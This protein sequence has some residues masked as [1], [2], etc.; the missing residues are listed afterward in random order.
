MTFLSFV[1]HR[2]CLNTKIQRI[3]SRTNIRITNNKFRWKTHHECNPCVFP[4]ISIF[5]KKSIVAPLIRIFRTEWK[6]KGSLLKSHGSAS[7][8]DLRLDLTSGPVFMILTWLIQPTSIHDP[9]LDES[10]RPVFMILSWMNP[11]DQYS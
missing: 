2:R 8:R 4:T 5:L 7:N 11:A 10:C 6:L 3:Y 9:K 1:S